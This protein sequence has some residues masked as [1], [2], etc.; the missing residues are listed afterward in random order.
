MYVSLF[1]FYLVMFMFWLFCFFFFFND[2]A[3]TDIYTYGHPLSLHDALPIS[4]LRMACGARPGLRRRLRDPPLPLPARNAG[5]L[6]RIGDVVECR[7]AQH[8]RQI[9]RAHV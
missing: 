9:G 1:I 2:T 3:T 8:H 7:A 5:D 6:Q 4:F